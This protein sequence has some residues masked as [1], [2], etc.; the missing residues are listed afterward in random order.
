M[1]G[2]SRFRLSLLHPPLL[3]AALALCA[4]DRQSEPAVENADGA[5]LNLPAIPAPEPPIDRAGL[6]AAV[7]EAA[8]AAS[9][10]IPAPE[11]LQSLDGRQFQLRIRFGCSGP[12]QALGSQPLGWTYDPGTRRLRIRAR[13]TIA[14]DDPLVGRIGGEQFESVEGFW[15]PRPWLLQ[16]V[17]PAS[18]AVLEL[19]DE[20]PPGAEKDVAKTGPA[21][22]TL[23]EPL[24]RA[25]RIGIAQFFTSTDARTR[26]RDS[27]PYEA[28]KTLA[29]GSAI[30][31][32]GFDLVLSGRLRAIPGSGVIECLA[33]SADSPPECI[34]SAQFQRVWIEDPASS[35]V[36]AEWGGG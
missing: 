2:L 10:G 13:P 1:F 3:C 19:S 15:V 6:L 9:A 31:S 32:Q 4:C 25:P 22:S 26:R 20:P 12:S 27:R 28:A 29:E 8:S 34:V 30:P 14:R 18:S 35:E 36:Y 33:K 23:E 16:P 17:C 7:A 5:A 24:P 11:S 21:G